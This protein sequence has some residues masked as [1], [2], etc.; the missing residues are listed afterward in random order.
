MLV[1]AL[2]PVT[3]QASAH[4]RAIGLTNIL[5]FLP[6]AVMS[7]E[8]WQ[9]LATAAPLKKPTSALASGITQYVSGC[10]HHGL[11]RDNLRGVILTAGEGPL[12]RHSALDVEYPFIICYSL[13]DTCPERSRRI[14]YSL[15]PSSSVVR[16]LSSVIHRH[17]NLR[18]L[19]LNNL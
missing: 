17:F 19:R 11:M 16:R 9:K 2:I 13:F 4:P 5:L 14:H 15:R 1:S 3:V 12:F 8:F 6:D 7:S 10:E 18:T